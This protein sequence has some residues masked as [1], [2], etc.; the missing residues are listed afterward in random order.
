MGAQLPWVGQTGI[1]RTLSAPANTRRYARVNPKADCQKEPSLTVSPLVLGVA[2]THHLHTDCLG[3]CGAANRHLAGAAA[4]LGEARPAP[5]DAP[6]SPALLSQSP[7]AKT[8]P[9][10]RLNTLILPLRH[11]FRCTT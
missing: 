1:Y 2:G 10:Q 7:D 8:Y 5:P 6:T 4:L 11:P 3:Y 9:A